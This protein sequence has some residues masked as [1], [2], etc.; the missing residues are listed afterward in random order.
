MSF[1]K[2]MMAI[3]AVCAA[4]LTMRSMMRMRNEDMRKHGMGMSKHRGRWARHG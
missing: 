3:V 2:A 4:M 1:M